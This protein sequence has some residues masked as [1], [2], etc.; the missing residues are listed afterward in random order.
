MEYL[1]YVRKAASYIT[2][3]I[4][5]VPDTAVVLGSGLGSLADKMQ[6]KIEIAYPEIP[7]LAS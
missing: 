6:D 5:E 7:H 3:R 1:D 4:N 2:M